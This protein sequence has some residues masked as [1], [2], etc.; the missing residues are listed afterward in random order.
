[1]LCPHELECV[2]PSVIRVEP[3]VVAEEGVGTRVDELERDGLVAL[4]GRHVQSRSHPGRRSCHV[5]SRAEQ[6]LDA[7]RR[8][9]PRRQDEGRLA[10]AGPCVH[11]RAVLQRAE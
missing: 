5:G 9:G 2:E 7:R 3:V 10:L 4:S 8:A 6:Q 1:M 11:V